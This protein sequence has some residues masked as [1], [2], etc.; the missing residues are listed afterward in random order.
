MDSS[1]SLNEENFDNMSESYSS[2]SSDE[3]D[4]CNRE[5]IEAQIKSMLVIK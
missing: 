4:D 2:E 3:D 5:A 1:S